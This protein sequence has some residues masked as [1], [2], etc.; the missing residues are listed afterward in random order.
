MKYQVEKKILKIGI[1]IN[2]IMALAGFLIYYL[3]QAQILSFDGVYSLANA[4]GATIA[5]KIISSANKE[6]YENLYNIIL[7]LLLLIFTIYSIIIA[8]I[9]INDYHNGMLGEVISGKSV[10]IY[11]IIMVIMCLSLAII[12]YLGYRKS[13]KQ[14][15]ILATNSRLALLD[16]L[17]SAIIGIVLIFFNE[18][19]PDS[20][21]IFLKYIGDDILMMI[22]G[23]I[24]VPP[25]IK[26]IINGIKK[27]KK[28]EDRER[29][30][31]ER[32]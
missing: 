12:Y 2:L 26:I 22:V 28:L 32:I 20:T 9:S 11:V 15:I 19:N 16:A 17:F 29:I 18:I 6:K 8:F 10:L 21:Y 24:Y 23:I 14:S 27:H 30:N 5:I 4:L 3:T 7:N 25:T 13:N 1:V 31:R